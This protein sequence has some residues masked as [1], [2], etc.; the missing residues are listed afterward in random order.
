MNTNYGYALGTASTPL[1]ANEERITGR[2]ESAL[3]EINSLTVLCEQIHGVVTSQHVRDELAKHPN[4]QGLV[5][6]SKRIGDDLAELRQV[7][8]QIG[9]AL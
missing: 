8:T 7:I 9:D 3:R 6:I 4:P 2:L 5:E 1:S